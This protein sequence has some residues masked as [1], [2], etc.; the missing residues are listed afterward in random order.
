MAEPPFHLDQAS[1]DAIARR[2][3]ELLG[4]LPG[5]ARLPAR[6]AGEIAEQLGTSA[7]W[8]RANADELGG[9][10]L[11]GGPKAPLR[12]DPEV[13]LEQLTARSASGRSEAPARRRTKPRTAP[14][15]SASGG[16]SA[17]LLP[18]RGSGVAESGRS[19]HIRDRGESEEDDGA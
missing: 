2:V 16:H 17:P 6:T 15:P 5:R 3:V 11:G 13:V 12:F 9:V 1:I 19:L 14:R 18:V 10:R 8:V 4:G 7:E